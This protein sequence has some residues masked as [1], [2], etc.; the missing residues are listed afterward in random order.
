LDAAD[1]LGI[2]PPKEKIACPGAICKPT[3]MQNVTPIG[4]TVAERSVTGER[5]NKTAK[6]YPFYTGVWR[7]A[8]AVERKYDVAGRLQT[9]YDIRTTVMLLGIVSH[10]LDCCWSVGTVRTSSSWHAAANHHY[11]RLQMTCLAAVPGTQGQKE[12]PGSR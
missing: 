5:E 12:V 3:I 2:P 8:N 7:V 6:I 10:L 4:A 1:P 11:S 9:V